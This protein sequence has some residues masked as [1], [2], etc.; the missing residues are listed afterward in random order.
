MECIKCGKGIPDAAPYC[1]WCGKKQTQPPRKTLKRPNGAGSVYKLSGRRTHPW[2]AARNRVVI[3]YFGKKIDAID[4]LAR[5]TGKDITERYNMTFSDVYGD[6]KVEHYRDIGEKSIAGYDNAYKNCESLYERKFRELRTQD[7]Q[8]VVD[9]RK[10]QSRSTQAKFKNL[11]MQL[12]EWAIRE[13]ISTTNYAQY[14][15][16]SGT[17]AEEKDIFSTEEISKLEADASPAAKVVLMMIYTGMRIGELFEVKTEDYHET[18]VVGGKKTKAGR[19]RIIPI[20][21][22]GRKYFAELAEHA[23]GDLLISGRVG[24]KTAA[25]YRKREYYPLLE[26][27]EIARKTPHAAR[28]TFASWAV[29]AG[30]RTDILQ[31]IIGHANY[32]TTAEIYVHADAKELVGAVNA[33]S[34]LLVTETE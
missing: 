4:A 19:N 26:R 32:S 10:E 21:E 1:C 15:K 27:L 17:K 5:L 30:M 33:V 18:Y 29:A 31:K 16:L 25:N 28:H 9:L 12:S 34:N 24:Q 6:W 2:V 3:G 7:F 13:E 22:E 20:R 23:T 11:F 14:V 8:E